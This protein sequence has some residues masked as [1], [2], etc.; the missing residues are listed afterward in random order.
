MGTV[1]RKW[2]KYAEATDES[3]NM[4]F[5]TVAEVIAIQR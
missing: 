3:E 2:E 1:Y 4:V 5:E